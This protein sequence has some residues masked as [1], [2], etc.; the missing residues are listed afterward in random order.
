MSQSQGRSEPLQQLSCL[1]SRRPWGYREQRKP[2]TP[3]SS[4]GSD[5][6][7]EFGSER[8]VLLADVRV[9]SVW[10]GVVV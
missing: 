9:V 3:F 1:G 2:V 5:T 6:T 10:C 7:L 4:V 8:E